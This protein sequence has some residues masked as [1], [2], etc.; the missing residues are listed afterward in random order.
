M[1]RTLLLIGIILLTAGCSLAP[2]YTKPE[3]PVP[4]AWPEGEAYRKAG[5]EITT[6]EVTSLPWRVFITDEKLV[7]V[8]EMALENNRDLRLAAL[9]VERARAL[10]RI[11][12]SE[13][14][15]AADVVGSGTRKRVPA[16][17]SDSG[18]AR[19]S[20]QYSVD[21]GVFS[22][23]IDFFGRIRSLKDRALEEYLATEEARR[24]AQILLISEVATAYL[25][26]AAERENLELAKSTLEAREASYGL[27]KKL[28]DYGLTSELDLRRAQTTVD[29]AR[30]DV[31]RQVEAA[32]Q[33][34]NA[35]A[36]L[37]GSPVPEDLLPAD[38]G[39]VSPP[40]EIVPGLSSEV[41]LGRPDILAAEH[42][43][44]AANASIGAARAAFFP[45]ISLTAAVGTASAELS[46]LFGSGS[47]T[48]L[49]QP[50][51]VLPIFDARTWAAYDA[52]RAEEKIILTRYERAIQNA[53]RE[54]A[55]GLAVLGMVDE[56]V[57]AQRSL[58]EATAET[59][60]LSNIRYEKGVDSYL[61]VLDAQRSLYVA[62]KAL[63][64]VR[65]KQLANRV[66]LYTALGGGS[67]GVGPR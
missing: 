42:Q 49:F 5:K 60:R 31:A 25:A 19:T 8:V 30:A 46:G 10:Y 16:D 2:T 29:G 24:G 66:R 35:L 58:V 26:L 6:P 61:G 4:G 15:P 13:L 45:R 64:A 34:E 1:K 33:G 55:D 65:L 43:L 44:K 63:I 27:I 21:L 40:R 53:F 32:A 38:L 52:A 9:N 14:F 3:A 41:L 59:Y 28:Y 62:Q 23:E 17:L 56:Q 11:Q 12:R 20:E 22:W 36:L 54:V 51:V 7:K 57:A 67:P 50:G 48:W 18:Q 47:G 39:S 37:A